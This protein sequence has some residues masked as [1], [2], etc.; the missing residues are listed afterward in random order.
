MEG[1]F[2]LLADKVFLPDELISLDN[3]PPLAEMAPPP[4][5]DFGAAFVKMFLT[6]IAL[7]L[8]LS[9]SYWLIKK[10]IQNRL[11]K[12]GGEKLIYVVEKRMISPKTALYLIEIEGKKVLLAESHLEVKRLESWP[13]VPTAE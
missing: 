12:G 1:M 2:F 6:L 9:L 10:I 4:P 3:G 7:I 11:Q 5:G 13:E 8:L